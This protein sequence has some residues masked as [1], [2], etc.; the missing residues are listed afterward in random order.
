MPKKI[1]IVD[2]SKSVRTV[3]G[4][5]LRVAGYD[6]VHA[7]DGDEG[8][9]VLNEDSSIDMII[10]DFNMPNMDGLTF[11]EKLREIAGFGSKPV[12]ML[13]TEHEQIRLNK[14]PLVSLASWIT[15]PVQPAQV[16]DIV[17]KI[18]PP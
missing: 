17:N 7:T 11:I 3:I 15:K 12:C 1:L 5:T 8:L 9:T 18:L 6:V 4:T 2:D 10:T 14:G 13:T 16:I